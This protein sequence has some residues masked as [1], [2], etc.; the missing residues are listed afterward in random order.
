[1]DGGVD[2]D[3]SFMLYPEDYRIYLED[4][5]RE[6][7]S[8]AIKLPF[9]EEIIIGLHQELLK[10]FSIKINY[11]RK[12]QKDILENVLFSPDQNMDWYTTE[13]DTQNWWIP[14]ETI[15]PETD[16]LPEESV[17]L[18]FMSSENAPLMFDRLK[19]VPELTRKYRSIEFSFEKRMSHNWQLLGSLVYSETT[20][21]INQDQVSSSGF[22]SAADSPNY[23]VNFPEDSKLNFDR[24][25]VLKL[26]GTYRFP[27][28]F[29]LSFYFS[30][31]SG[32]PWIRSVSVIP[33][34]S[35]IEENKVYGLPTE[36]LLETPGTRRND[37]YSNLDI[38]VEKDFKLS[39]L[40]K[41]SLYVDV[42]N[43]IG[44]ER[45]ILNRNDGGYW[46]PEDEMTTEGI[47]ILS[48]IYNRV[49]SLLRDRVFKLT[50][51][52]TF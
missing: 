45:N 38:R 15:I 21:N 28:D 9:T 48:P 24:P 5:Y 36:V 11:I 33:P 12:V 6:R 42:L 40:K 39:G 32:N 44:H 23:F 14:F 13:L 51:K 17:T 37:T 3:D 46:F 35:W 18:Y 26:M 4:M 7:I 47:R 20:G 43:A 27:Y 25:L 1:M 50:I 31:M 52:Y 19:N 29:Y 2:I 16:A 49:T 34:S 22:S 10:G 41:L 8:P 30:H